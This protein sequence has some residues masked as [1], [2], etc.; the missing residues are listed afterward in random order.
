MKRTFNFIIFCFLAI[1]LHA[2]I[3]ENQNIPSFELKEITVIKSYKFK[4]QKEESKYVQLEQNIRAV[5]P[6]LQIIRKEYSRVTYELDFYEGKT[7][8]EYLK[9]SEEQIKNKYLH[10]LSGLSISQGRLLLKL[11]GREFNQSPY[12]ILKTYRN[13]VRATIWRGAAALCL[14]DLDANYKPEDNPMIEHIMARL[15][16][17]YDEKNTSKNLSQTLSS[18]SDKESDR[19]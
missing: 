14:A 12:E 9:W 16:A 4:N 1:G 3:Q 13:G 6:L 5:Y 19:Q 8:N 17:E 15:N 18:F 10:L 2:Q 11:I 7:R